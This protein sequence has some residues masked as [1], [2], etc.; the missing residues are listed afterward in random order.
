M[1]LRAS[2]ACDHCRASKKR[3][4]P[5]LPCQNC[6]SAGVRCIVRE[7][8]RPSRK[9]KP[10]ATDEVLPDNCPE[11]RTVKPSSSR[12]LTPIPKTDPADYI[13]EIVFNYI[14]ST[15]DVVLKCS[16]EEP[17]AV[18]DDSQLS[19]GITSLE[20]VCI[21]VS[22]IR[23][24]LSIPAVE[25]V[26]RLSPM[27]VSY[28]QTLAD[29]IL[30][31]FPCHKGYMPIQDLINLNIPFD[32]LGL[33]LS[34]LALC[35]IY[36]RQTDNY[37]SAY[38]LGSRYL[39]KNCD[40][41]PSLDLCIACYLQHLYLLR[42]GPDNQDTSALAM[43]IRTAHDLKINRT[44][45]SN[46]GTLP[47]KLYLFLYFHDQCCAMS[48]NGP[49][50]IKTTDYTANVFDHVL[51][52]EPDFRPLFD[53]LVANGQVLEALYGKPCDYNN[54]YHLEE[55]L[56]C[57]SKSARK[58]M[59]PFLGFDRA[60]MNYETPVQ[61]HMF[62]ARITLRAHRL[63]LTEDWIP[64]MSI[65]VR[66][67]QMILLL[68]FQA[69][70]PSMA[71]GAQD[72]HKLPAGLPLLSMEGRMPL[73]WRQVKRIMTSAFILIYA[74]WHGEVTFEEVCRGTAMALVLHECQRM[75]WGRELD[76]IMAVLRDIAGIC[77]MTI[78]PNLSSLLPDVDL[79]VLRVIA[80]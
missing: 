1:N 23:Q 36:F 37:A 20:P 80:G 8:A 59:Q 39:L 60:N 32:R 6:V 45:F 65:C 72:L 5:P 50:L 74:Y 19:V 35:C 28:I 67:S 55:L 43:A 57:V 40:V 33:I 73:T 22:T 62:W 16:L 9:R 70:N 49:P 30:P 46:R 48:N 79:G 64:S 44:Y 26:A 10:R 68:Y 42:T 41:E 78:L 17:T 21:D 56:G 13:K 27:E 18:P 29:D 75:R 69:Y 71:P 61:I 47:T 25:L 15:Y 31:Q 24:I 63:T 3:C 52:E 34:T 4:R 12:E 51:E 58:P 38:F 53:I 66:S 14:Y 54:I 11:P 76:G 7:K 2:K 77:G